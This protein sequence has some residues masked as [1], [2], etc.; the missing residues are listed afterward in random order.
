[1][2][3]IDSSFHAYLQSELPQLEQN[4]NFEHVNLNGENNAGLLFSERPNL[5][6]PDSKSQQWNIFYD[7]I[8]PKE[9][10]LTALFDATRLVFEIDPSLFIQHFTTIESST[11]QH[12][13]ASL[14]KH[15]N[16]PHYCIFFPSEDML[17]QESNA[18]VHKA[19]TTQDSGP[20]YYILSLKQQIPEFVRIFSSSKIIHFACS[21]EGLLIHD[22]DLPTIPRISDKQYQCTLTHPLHRALMQYAFQLRYHNLQVQPDVVQSKESFL[23]QLTEISARNDCLTIYR[24]VLKTLFDEAYRKLE[25]SIP[26]TIV[27]DENVIID[28]LKLRD[29][30][31]SLSFVIGNHQNIQTLDKSFPAF[32]FS[33]ILP[34]SEQLA[35]AWFTD[36]S[37]WWGQTAALEQLLNQQSLR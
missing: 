16:F 22:S 20:L 37:N 1:M 34:N 11:L 29:E 26:K 28:W 18:I 32:A 6:D 4:Y 27:K 33:H 2:N 17:V 35:E 5:N 31:E 12:L 25:R 13:G 10:D 36:P 30:L 21:K 9:E 15:K 23:T 24:D 3:K 14:Y 19:S 7:Q 8:S